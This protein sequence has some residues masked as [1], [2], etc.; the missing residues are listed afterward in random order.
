MQ[1]PLHKPSSSPNSVIKPIYSTPAQLGADQ[2]P[3]DTRHQGQLPLTPSDEKGGV[4]G[5]EHH[6]DK[7]ER[8]SNST[9]K[10]NAPFLYIFEDYQD[11]HDQK[12]AYKEPQSLQSIIHTLNSRKK[13]NPATA[14]ES[15]A[16]PMRHKKSLVIAEKDVLDLIDNN[17]SSNLSDTEPVYAPNQDLASS[18]NKKNEM[19]RDMMSRYNDLRGMLDKMKSTLR[20]AREETTA[21][22]KDDSNQQSP[23]PPREIVNSSVQ[24]NSSMDESDD[25]SDLESFDDFI[26]Y[27]SKSRKL[28]D[29]WDNSRMFLMQVAACMGAFLVRTLMKITTRWKGSLKV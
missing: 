1:Q 23:S 8:Q 14:K 28:G 11:E 3:Q 26:D 27:R 4:A 17:Q 21:A 12:I 10:T 13:R 29:E 25:I 19:R 9:V 15:E 2:A 6:D 7:V 18:V 22:R 5:G 24:F 20:E 16:I